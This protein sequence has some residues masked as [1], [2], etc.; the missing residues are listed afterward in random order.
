MRFTLVGIC[1]FLLFCLFVRNVLVMLMISLDDFVNFFCFCCSSLFCMNLDRFERILGV[2][3]CLGNRVGLVG[4]LLF[5]FLE[6]FKM[7][8]GILDYSFG[9]L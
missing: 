3:K 9:F 4:V 6:L 7:K 5:L 1:I 8:L 2:R